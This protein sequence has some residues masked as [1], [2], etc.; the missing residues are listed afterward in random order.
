MCG[1]NLY[2]NPL[3]WA[4]WI[5]TNLRRLDGGVYNLTRWLSTNSSAAWRIFPKMPFS[6][7]RSSDETVDWKQLCLMKVMLGIARENSTLGY[8]WTFTG[9]FFFSRKAWIDLHS[10]CFFWAKLSSKRKNNLLISNGNICGQFVATDII[11]RYFLEFSKQ[12]LWRF[13]RKCTTCEYVGSVRNAHV[14]SN[15]KQISSYAFCL[16]IVVK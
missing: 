1:K 10:V 6:S 9:R 13:I 15:A 8:Y 16:A 12:T 11:L 7:R 2:V 4:A 3:E 14:G 5:S